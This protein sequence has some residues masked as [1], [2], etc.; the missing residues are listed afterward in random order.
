M[1]NERHHFTRPEQQETEVWIDLM[2]ERLKC[3]PNKLLAAEIE[4]YLKTIEENLHNES[5]IDNCLYN[6]Q[7]LRL[8]SKHQPWT[9]LN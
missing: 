9:K 8:Q 6:I 5:L 7:I 4:Y 2:R 1:V 3:L